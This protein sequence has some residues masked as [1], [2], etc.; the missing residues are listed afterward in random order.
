ML[1]IAAH[2]KETGTYTDGKA[3]YQRYTGGHYQARLAT[4]VDGDQ[5]AGNDE[6]YAATMAL[7][8]NLVGVPA[9]VVLGALVPEGGI[10]TGADV[11]AWVEL[12]VADGTWRRLPT[13]EFMGTQLPDPRPPQ[14]ETTYTSAVVPPPAPVPPPSTVGDPADSDLQ[15]KVDRRRSDDGA[16]GFR[17]PGWLVGLLKYVGIPLALLLLLAVVVVALKARR[18]RRRRHDPDVSRRFSGGWAEVVDRARDLGIS[19]PAHGST[20]TE[21]ARTL[22][23]PSAYPVARAADDH[24][25]A[26]GPPSEADAS[27]YWQSVEALCRELRAA[28]PLRRRLVA[29]VSPASLLPDAPALE[30]AAAGRLGGGSC[31]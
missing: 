27:A 8:S 22:A 25:F 31:A 15:T 20:R 6:Q 19:L 24:V 30:R 7:L 12:R 18:R 11:E 10:V 21:Q 1:A 5:I 17:L 14:T 28:R 23:A 26:A 9:R 4:F 13:E 16:E 29:A 3:P 2:L